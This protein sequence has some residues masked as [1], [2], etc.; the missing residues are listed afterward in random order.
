MISLGFRA[1]HF[2]EH[3]EKDTDKHEK[4]ADD[5]HND[6]QV[7]Y[8]VFGTAFLGADK[9]DYS[10]YSLGNFSKYR[11]SFFDIDLVIQDG[12]GAF[13]LRAPPIC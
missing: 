6:C 13:S 7:C 2:L 8:I 1:L 4:I 9:I 11:T 3:Q 12:Y 5:G 10:S